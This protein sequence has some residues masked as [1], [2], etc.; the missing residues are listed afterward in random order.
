MN[1][2]GAGDI[3]LGGG[4][5]DTIEGRA[6]DDI[7]DGDRW[8][9][10]RIQVDVPSGPDA[11]RYFANHMTDQLVDESGQPAFGGRTLDQLMFD[12]SLSPGMLSINRSIDNGGAAGDTDVAVYWD[13][14]ENYTGTQNGDGSFT[15]THDDATEGVDPD[16]IT[17]Q[18]RALEGTD[19]LLNIEV[20]R[21]ADMDMTVADLPPTGAPVISDMTPTRTFALE[22]DLSLITDPN[23]VASISPR[24]QVSNDG[25]ATWA[26]I[27]AATGTTFT[28]AAVQV[29]AML[30]VAALVSDMAGGINTGHSL[31]TSVVGDVINGTIFAN[32]PAGTEGAGL[33][34]A[35]AGSDTVT[36][37]GLDDTI[38]GGSASDLIDAG[39]GNDVL[40][41]GTGGDI[42]L[43]GAGNDTVFWSVTDPL[44]MLFG[45]PIGVI[46]DGRDLIVGGDGT[47]TV[48]IEGNNQAEVFRVYA[49]ADWLA[50]AGNSAASLN[51]ETEIV[52]TRTGTGAGSIIAELVGIEEIDI[53]TGAG[54]DTF[55]FAPTAQAD[56]DVVRGF[57]RGEDVLDLSAIDANGAAAGD[58][59]FSLRAAGDPVQAG[60]LFLS[61]ISSGGTVFTVVSGHVNG[62]GVADFS[63][64]LVGRVPLSADDF[65]F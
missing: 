64:A 5:S 34:S 26:D 8:L 6:G 21:F 51:T 63:F 55:V 24:W 9:N 62:D 15:V 48:V 31:P 44:F 43:A 46:T 14:R 1:T 47:D 59:V 52:I 10:V 60:S 17:G 32:T 65:I 29:G 3:L 7:I 23:G 35:G 20:L 30:R 18:E 27:P 54:A 39:A 41:G 49:R 28:P 42:I 38:F 53:R 56:G 58:G 4:G 13:V 25:G 61:E 33:I 36:G 22:A 19:R 50:E 16:P 11:G 37:S 57:V 40:V 12:R 2:S 45:T